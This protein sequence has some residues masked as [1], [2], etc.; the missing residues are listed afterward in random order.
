MIFLSRVNCSDID[1]LVQNIDFPAV[2]DGPLHRTMFPANLLDEQRMEVI[3][4]RTINMQRA[5]DSGT[6]FYKACTDDGTMVGFIGWVVEKP[7]CNNS[8]LKKFKEVVSLPQT[9]NVTAWQDL[10][11]SLMKERR[12]VLDGL[13]NVLRK[14]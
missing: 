5:F 3:R 11:K 7:S 10:S 6:S 14:W 2:Q 1:V 13:E 12:R 4:W 9:L 8:K